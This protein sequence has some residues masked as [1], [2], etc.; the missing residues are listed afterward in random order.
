M[1]RRKY[2]TEV[3]IEQARKVHKY[4]YD[5]SKVK[6]E[7]Y[8]TNVCII[9]TK[10]GEFWQTPHNH[11][12][13]QNCPKCS[14]Q[15]YANTLELFIEKARKVHGEKYDYSK[16]EYNGNKKKICI[17]CHKHGEF[18]QKPNQ[19]LNGQ[20]CPD[21]ACDFLKNN[22]DKMRKTKNDFIDE[23]NKVHNNKYDYSKV[24]YKNNHTKVCII[25][26][27]HG[28]FWQTPINHLKNHGCPICNSSKLEEEIYTFL[29]NN[30]I[31][32]KAQHHTKWLGLQSLDFY[33][34]KENIAIECQGE[35]HFL[36]SSNKK[37]FFNEEK[38]AKIKN[39]DTLKRELCEQHGIKIFYY[40]NLGIDYPYK[41]YE[42]FDEM[43]KAIKDYSYLDHERSIMRSKI[44]ETNVNINGIKKVK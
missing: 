24:M 28:E 39:R 1:G 3:F 6:Y 18:W 22:A 40:S 19:H 15:S 21:C 35:Q 12:N 10:H 13:G 14:H 44:N 37:S 8:D 29:K 43:L 20:G 17:I 23:A 38:V 34:P 4:K 27:K 16:V 26:P 32:F 42:D 31:D 41:V 30:D 36:S 11:L 25:C 7:G 5:Y 9:C 33:L 2:N